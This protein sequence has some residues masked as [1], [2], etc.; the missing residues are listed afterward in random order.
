MLLV[1]KG[2]FG[3]DLRRDG[4]EGKPETH[5]WVPKLSMLQGRRQ[6]DTTAEAQQNGFSNGH[7]W[8]R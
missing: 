7:T 8:E 3:S 5:T 6:G 4:P 1:W 2:K